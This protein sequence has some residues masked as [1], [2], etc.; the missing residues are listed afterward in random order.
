MP[1][2][3]PRFHRGYF[4]ISMCGAF[5]TACAWAPS[6]LCQA[7]NS[8]KEPPAPQ[9]SPAVASLLA[10]CEKLQQAKQ[11]EEAL[12]AADRALAAAVEAKDLAGEALSHSGRASALVQ[13]G[14]KAEAVAAWQAAGD[15]WGRAGEGP[16]QIEPLVL[17]A[18]QLWATDNAQ[19]RK[20]LERALQVA[21]EEHQR[22]FAAA[23]ELDQAA[24]RLRALETLPS[25]TPAV[26]EE[27]LSA[28]AGVRLGKVGTLLDN[29]KYPEAEAWARRWVSEAEAKSGPDSLETAY[30]LDALATALFVVKVTE[31]PEKRQIA[32]RALAIREKSLGPEHLDVA[33]SLYTL[34][35][36]LWQAG[37][38]KE[39]KDTWERALAI[40][41]KALGPAHAAVRILLAN[42]AAVLTDMGDCAAALPLAERYVALLEKAYSPEHAFF[43]R[44]LNVLFRAHY[45][46]GNYTEARRVLERALAIKEK[47]S[48]PEHASVASDRINL[49]QLL[50]EIGDLTEAKRNYELA[51]PAFE[52]LYGPES[53]QVADSLGGLARVAASSGDYA[54]ARALQERAL[55]NY[56]NA[57]GPEHPEL[58]MPLISLAITLTKIG[59]QAKAQP[60]YERALRLWEQTRGS[61]SSFVA[62]ALFQLAGLLQETGELPKA[63]QLY[64]R[65]LAIQEKTY[66]P[67]HST[68]AATL[69]GLAQVRA[70]TGEPDDAFSL[71]LRAE[72]A[73]RDHWQLVA[74]TLSEREALAY[75]RERASGLDV[76]LTLAAH[77]TPQARAQKDATSRETTRDMWSAVVRSR[78]LV[79]DEMAGRHRTVS[80]SADPQ[81]AQLAE[82]LTSARERLARLVVR[83]PGSEPPERYHKLLDETRQEKER[84]ERAL[85][86]RS[87]TFRAELARAKIG[88]DDV[89][90]A[91]PSEAAIVA[92]VRYGRHDF[93]AA[94]PGSK[95]PDPV[96]HYLAFVWNH[97]QAEPVVVPLGPAA[98]IE[99][100]VTK[101]RRQIAQ[102]SRSPGRAAKRSEADY[103]R[104]GEA[105]HRAVWSPV[106][107]YLHLRD[108][109]RVF[110]VPD[111]ALHLVNFAALPTGESSYLLETGP[112][113]H[114]LSAER[115]LVP[116]GEQEEKGVDLLAIGA[117]AF[118]ENSLF[119]SL[120]PQKNETQESA[121]G[122]AHGTPTASTYRGLRSAC[123]NFQ[124]MQFEA[125]SAS[126]R[127]VSDVAALWRRPGRTL[128][129]TESN[130]VQLTGAAASES[131]FKQQAQG[132]RVLHLATHGFFLGGKCASALG[133]GEKPGGDASVLSPGENPLLLSGLALAGANHRQAAGPDE[134]DGILTAEEIA[135]LDLSGVEWAVLSACDTGIGEVKVGEGVLGLRRAFEVAGARTLILSLWPVEDQAA[136]DWM[137][138]L[139]RAR[140]VL[141]LTTIDAVHQANLHT[142]RQRRA[143]GQ[144][145]HP[146]YWAGFVAAGDW[147]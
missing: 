51:L 112:R 136:R 109:R 83:G 35:R 146:F 132:K 114:Y 140:L 98:S 72:E 53:A 1:Q 20:Q 106:S 119:A 19:A 39:A 92:Y 101:M 76:A 81:M 93:S 44:G 59:E 133:A 42:L 127:E 12:Q 16:S 122:F 45:C 62:V 17:A 66:G 141:G 134:E 52:K 31:I 99:A 38:Y 63:R 87:Q 139:Y 85:A 69:R 47:A 64:E 32:E 130:A 94:K 90:A 116:V 124:T 89:A 126:A 137:R 27:F 104:T 24:T 22:G 73:G 123:E 2:S 77:K 28:A 56:E 71:A 118:Q 13:L 110:I 9:A 75:A 105:L 46:A 125:L 117:P 79:L 144:S 50:W 113:I 18:L 131:A 6:A 102:E 4:I 61:E 115:D 147:R 135:A 57:L 88:F 43:G 14:R 41:E 15:A 121:P 108:S 11:H 23:D 3:R 7:S 138:Q 34:G 143:S 8:V 103:R 68:V 36:I 5:L 40:R 74:T 49:G 100:L 60:L 91:L 55:R 58:G 48:G 10:E 86:E 25:G 80:S 107:P 54:T 97:T 145:T 30:A 96:P 142:L 70:M 26:A 21:K 67:D 84:A 120:R 128:R 82:N 111:G 78:A 65:A 29:D 129:G 33:R 37:E 95:R